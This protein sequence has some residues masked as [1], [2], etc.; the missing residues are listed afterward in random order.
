MSYSECQALLSF[1]L[2][3][4]LLRFTFLRLFGKHK[5]FFFFFFLQ[6]VRPQAHTA[7]LG[8]CWDRLGICHLIKWHAFI[9]GCSFP[10]GIN[11]FMAAHLKWVEASLTPYRATFDLDPSFG[12]AA[13]FNFAANLCGGKKGIYCKNAH[14]CKLLCGCLCMSIASWW[15]CSSEDKKDRGRQCIISCKAR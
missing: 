6:P 1:H 11:W 15:H 14:R 8:F 13:A 5:Y 2:P 10:T 7:R 3:L 9:W 4:G 12:A